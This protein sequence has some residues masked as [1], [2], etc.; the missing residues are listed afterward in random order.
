MP[1]DEE[2]RAVGQR[3]PITLTMGVYQCAF[4]R[5]WFLAEYEIEVTAAALGENRPFCPSCGRP[6]DV[7]RWQIR[8]EVLAE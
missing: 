7:V 4:C 8:Q 2:C 5:R 6:D 3:E 1:M